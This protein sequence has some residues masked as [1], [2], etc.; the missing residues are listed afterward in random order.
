MAGLRAMEGVP[1]LEVPLGSGEGIGVCAVRVKIP[2]S[3]AN[4][5]APRFTGIILMRRP[6]DEF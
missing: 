1:G 3:S 6:E 2:V 4:S 5:T